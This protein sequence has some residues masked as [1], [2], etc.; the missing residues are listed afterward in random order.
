MSEKSIFLALGFHNHQPVGNFDYIIDQAYEK[1]Y[2]PFLECLERNSHIRAALHYSGYLLDYLKENQPGWLQKLQ[3]LCRNGQVEM[4]SGA[5]YEPILSNISDRDKISQVKKMNRAIK[6][7]FNQKPT[8]MWCAERIWEPSLP[9]PLSLAGIG[10]TVLDE[11]HFRAAGLDENDIFGHYVTD[12]QGHPLCVFPI[13]RKLRWKIPHDSPEE[14]I[15]FLKNQADEKG[16]RL[17][18]FADDGEKFGE[19]PDT[20]K[21]VWEENWLDKFFALI[22]ENQDWLKVITFN[23]YMQLYP[24]KGLIYLPTASYF[25]MSTWALPA[26]KARLV[27]EFNGEIRE[28]E[29]LKK[30]EDFIR[31]GFWRN[32]LVK[33]PESNQMQKNALYISEKVQRMVTR[34]REEAQDWL[35]RAQ[36]NCAY[37]H[38][39]FGGIYLPHLRH[40]IH[41]C[42]IRAENMA[43][44]EF[45]KGEPYKEVRAMDL[46][47]DFRDE[48]IINTANLKLGFFP[49]LGGSLYELDYKPLAVNL[50]DT[51]TRRKEVY[52]EN[53]V[54]ELEDQPEKAEKLKK[55]L[56]YDKYRRCSFIDHFTSQPVEV[57]RFKSGDFEELGDFIENPYEIFTSEKDDKAILTLSRKGFIK[58]EGR[59]CPLEIEKTYFVPSDGNSFSV[60]YWV[61]NNSEEELELDFYCELDFSFLSREPET[62]YII[63]NREVIEEEETRIESERIPLDQ[64]GVLKDFEDIIL[65]DGHRRYQLIMDF[66]QE[67]RMLHFPIETISRTMKDYDEVYQSTV[68]VPAWVLK[69]EAGDTWDNTMTFRIEEIP[70][71][72][73]TEEVNNL[74]KEILEEV[75]V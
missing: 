42:L 35:F 58:K 47:R 9:K 63:V 17:A 50:C 13:N 26:E 62:N 65:R 33:Y 41:E 45:F 46:N 56:E 74:E 20:H 48:V 59:E 31:G 54:N 21:I 6:T 53:L 70:E 8:G 11:Y 29:K 10:Y 4:L 5:Y 16:D 67:S 43:D 32:F 24:P 15:E 30:Y 69:L 61:I 73:H 66:G 36:C 23:E 44:E 27:Q 39:V 1:A 12:E 19:W 51:L 64:Y 28:N 55:K 38:G 18:V 3:K 22:K 52:H 57:E 14:V 68:V 40:K 75:E 25:E 49:H 2:L 34:A 37:W 7:E 71:E 72:E 60:Q